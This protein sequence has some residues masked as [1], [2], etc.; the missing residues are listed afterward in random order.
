[1]R[2]C[3]PHKET[4][5][6]DSKIRRKTGKEKILEKVIRNCHSTVVWNIIYFIMMRF[7]FNIINA[8]A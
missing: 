6:T 2:Q 1:M 5:R 4:K 8:V 3:Q 7:S